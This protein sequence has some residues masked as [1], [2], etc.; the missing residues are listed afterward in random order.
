VEAVEAYD[1]QGRR[2][3]QWER[4]SGQEAVLELGGLPK[5]LYLLRFHSQGQTASRRVVLR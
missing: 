5:G 3:A 2:V 4:A 1:L